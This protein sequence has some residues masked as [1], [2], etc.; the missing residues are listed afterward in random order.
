MEHIQD[1]PGYEGM[2]A[3]TRDGK[4]WSHT[5]KTN[6][7][8]KGGYRT[9]GGMFLKLSPSVSASGK[10][11]YRVAFRN[12]EGVRRS[13]LVHRLVAA[14]YIPNPDNL[15]FINHL[16]GVTTDNRVENLEWCTAKRNTQHAYDNG[17]IKMPSQS[18]E[19]NSQAKLTEADARRVKELSRNGMGD[20]AISRE[21]GINRS[22]VKDITKGK[23]WRHV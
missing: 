6:V 11:Y 23:T 2:Y 9:D 13:L 8:S 16:N 5:K 21:T 17:W 1:I 19:R 4:V 12:K 20:T 3:V 15:P 7:G 22:A 10:T 14:A 18:G